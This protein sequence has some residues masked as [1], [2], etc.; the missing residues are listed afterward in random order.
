MLFQKVGN[1]INKQEGE[2]VWWKFHVDAKEI[3]ND[4][5]PSTASFDDVIKVHK[6]CS[7]DTV[8]L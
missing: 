6:G 3:K 5:K 8:S 1:F 7:V 4:V 2:T